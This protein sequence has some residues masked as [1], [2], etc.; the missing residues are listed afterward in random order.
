MSLLK[1]IYAFYLTI[2]NRFLYFLINKEGKFKEEISKLSNS[3]FVECNNLLSSRDWETLFNIDKKLKNNL[4]NNSIQTKRLNDWH[5]IDKSA[6]KIIKKLTL[7]AGEYFMYPGIELDQ[8]QYQ[9]SYPS[10]FPP[11][12]MGWHID[13]HRKILKFFVYLTPVDTTNG[14]MRLISNSK[15][16]FDFIYAFLWNYLADLKYT[17]FT[18]EKILKKTRSKELLF[19]SVTCSKPTIFAIDTTSLHTST[20]LIQGERRVIVFNFKEPRF[21]ITNIRT[22]KRIRNFINFYHTKMVV[23]FSSAC[24]LKGGLKKIIISINSAHDHLRAKTF[25][26]KEP[27]TNKWL[28]FFSQKPFTLID[29]GSNIGI[30]S[31]YFSK[32]NARNRVIAIEPDS[33]S[34]VSLIRN[35]NLNKIKTIDSYPV[36]IGLKEKFSI[37]HISNF[38]SGAGAGGLD[39]EYQFLKNP[40]T[41]F[42]QG[43]Y[44]LSLDSFFKKLNLFKSHKNIIIKIDTDGNELDILKSGGKVLK[45]FAI[46]SI[47]VEINYRDFSELRFIENILKSYGFVLCARSNWCDFYDD[48]KIA[49]FYFF[50]KDYLNDKTLK[51]LIS[52]N[53]FLHEDFYIC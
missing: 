1:I 21:E 38:N 22:L 47:L 45:N 16:F 51:S 34:F 39:Y 44:A 23:L 37:F 31:L 52:G 30:Y 32:L 40:P 53:E 29:I 7:F 17:Y 35:V 33:S 3:G 8:T 50:R 27:D 14:A 9:I 2:K 48:T 24:A 19:S 13:D 4:S 28:E 11:P 36:A 20:S 15:G 18:K 42:H 10:N 41:I 26:F 12:G 49:N 43:V 25:K 6:N 46:K 5:K